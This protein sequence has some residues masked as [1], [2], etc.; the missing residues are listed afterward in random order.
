M[1]KRSIYEEA[2]CGR[3]GNDKVRAI[4]IEEINIFRYLLYIGVINIVFRLIWKILPIMIAIALP[5]TTLSIPATVLRVF[6]KLLK[7]FG[8]YILVSLVVLL[9][10][11]AIKIPR[12]AR[13]K[14]ADVNAPPAVSL[15]VNETAA[16]IIKS[17]R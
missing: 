6:G 5:I 7:I 4:S 8:H 1:I 15:K 11:S 2:Q 14:M 16:A 9:T 17:S 3:R 13:K 12:V 10:L